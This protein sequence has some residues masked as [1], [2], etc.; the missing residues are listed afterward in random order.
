MISEA[1]EETSWT[2]SAATSA[3]YAYGHETVAI[4]GSNEEWASGS[5]LPMV[6]ENSGA[7]SSAESLLM[8]SLAGG[9]FYNAYEY[10]GPDNYGLYYPTSTSTRDFTP[11]ARSSYVAD[12]VATNNCPPAPAAPASSTSTPPATAP[13]TSAASGTSSTRNSTVTIAGLSTYGISAVEYGYY[14][15]AGN[16]VANGTVTYTS[17]SAGLTVAVLQD[18]LVHIET[19]TAFTLP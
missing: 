5:N 7:T 8:A 11:V 1:A 4:G 9:A 15:S 19:K 2:S 14:T 17:T 3:L 16:F 18:Q 13:W 12:V 6:M 10:M